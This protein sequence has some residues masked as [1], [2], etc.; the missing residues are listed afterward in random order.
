MG[1]SSRRTTGVEESRVPGGSSARSGTTTGQVQS[2]TRGL[3]ILDVLAKAEGGL[4]DLVYFGSMWFRDLLVILV[5]G[6]P[7]IA[8]NRDMHGELS[9][10]LG[11]A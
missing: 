7:V 8:Y 4:E 5:G 1:T 11:Q 6:E 9:G 10:I 3:S 2:L